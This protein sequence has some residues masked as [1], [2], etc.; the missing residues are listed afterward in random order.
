MIDK[1]RS[2][3]ELTE[4]DLCA[5]NCVPGLCPHDMTSRQQ[6]A[7]RQSPECPVCFNCQLPTDSCTNGGN[8][9]Q[10]GACEC[11][12]GW[13]K[14]ITALFAS[15]RTMVFAHSRIKADST[16]RSRCAAHCMLTIDRCV[17][18]ISVLAMTGK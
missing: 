15:A 5:E 9:N 7:K 14:G 16:A 1:Y 6:L 11:P 3:A 18:V 17:K 8:C 2:G 12:V 4:I 10:S 13:G